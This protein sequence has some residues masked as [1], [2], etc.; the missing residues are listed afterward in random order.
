MEMLLFGVVFVDEDVLVTLERTTGEE[1]EAS[2]HFGELIDVEAGDGIEAGERL[3]DGADGLGDVRLFR[4]ESHEGL[5]KRRGTESND[6]GARRANH[7]V[8]ADA[9][10]AL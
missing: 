3:D 6:G 7:D 4:D 8:G 2:A 10:G 9:A 5:G 1:M